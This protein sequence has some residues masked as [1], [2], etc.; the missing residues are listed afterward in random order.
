L[1][2]ES[3]SLFTR[4]KNIQGMEEQTKIGQKKLSGVEF[5]PVTEVDVRNSA[6]VVHRSA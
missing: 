3:F 5:V 2:Q 6:P 4:S 1:K